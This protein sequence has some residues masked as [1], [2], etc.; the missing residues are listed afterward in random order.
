[1]LIDTHCHLNFKA[2]NQDLENVIKR[3]QENGIGKIIIPGTKINSSRKAIEIAKDNP[4]CFAAVGIHPHHILEYST[5]GKEEIRNTLRI[6]VKNNQVAAVGEIGMD[7]YHYRDY[8]PISEN[9]KKLQ[10]ELL[11]LQLEIAV[12][13]KLPVIIHCREAQKDLLE[14]IHSFQRDRPINGVFHCF[15]G[16]E[17]YLR[18]V[19]SLGF[20]IGFDGNITYPQNRHLRKLVKQTPLERLIL[21]T[22]SP[23][24]TPIPYRSVRNEPSNL[25]LI[26]R[27]IALIKATD[28]VEI[29][30]QTAN[31]ALNLFGL[32]KIDKGVKINRV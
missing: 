2:F 16:D 30:R 17:D 15:D 31:N 4:I 12:D 26:L 22:D 13:N 7:Y 1:M 18:K 9:D 6:L 21:E 23:Y 24:L 27:E 5:L 8:P 19:L 32:K 28:P 29:E 20:Y 14:M 3:A 10:N 25:T 11:L